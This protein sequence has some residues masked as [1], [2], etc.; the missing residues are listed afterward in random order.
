[1]RAIPAIRLTVLFVLFSEFV[2][3]FMATDTAEH[4]NRLFSFYYFLFSSLYSA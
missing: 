1:L 2:Y 4:G 3:A